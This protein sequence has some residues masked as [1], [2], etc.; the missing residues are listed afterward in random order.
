MKK[1]LAILVLGL[2]FSDN[3]YAE[4]YKC[5]LHDNHTFVI[6]TENSK[7]KILAT[8]D[9]ETGNLNIEDNQ[10]VRASAP[11]GGWT[12]IQVG[13]LQVE[14]GN[15]YYKQGGVYQRVSAADAE[16]IAEANGWIVP[17]R[18][19]ILAIYN[20]ATLVPMVTG[21]P[22][23]LDDRAFTERTRQRMSEL[24]ISG[25]FIAGHKKDMFRNERGTIGMIGGYRC[26]GRFWQGLN[27]NGLAHANNPSY[28][29]YS[30]GLRPVKR[31]AQR[32]GE[33][34]DLGSTTT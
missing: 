12:T 23:Q 24:G 13:D 9:P 28:D 27:S 29:D 25:G 30:Q 8:V 14:V 21:D 34:V 16:S 22:S 10:I 2:L 4:I 3:A 32:N 31:I 11:S 1:L 15:D 19:I 17:T 26:N 7:E 5:K 6:K 18:D 20:S 33:D